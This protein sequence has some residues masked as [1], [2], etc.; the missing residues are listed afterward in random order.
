MNF[1]VVL[2]RVGFCSEFGDDLSVNGNVS[3]KNE[4]LCGPPRGDAG[5]GNKFL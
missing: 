1:Y 3:A 2:I 4:L 5:L